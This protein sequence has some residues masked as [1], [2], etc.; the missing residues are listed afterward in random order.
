MR[1]VPVVAVAVALAV[2]SACRASSDSTP[3]NSGQ[4]IAHCE[5]PDNPY[6]DGSGHYAGYVW[7]QEHDGEACGGSGSFNEGCEE[8]ESQE[9]GYAE[10]ESKN[11]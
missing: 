9:A 5:E 10:C 2:A 3:E 4:T 7:G 1:T 8:H 11:K 6:S